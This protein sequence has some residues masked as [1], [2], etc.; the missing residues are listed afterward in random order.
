[1]IRARE[2]AWTVPLLLAFAGYLAALK[3]S[4]A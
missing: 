3:E 2:T 4:G 1:M